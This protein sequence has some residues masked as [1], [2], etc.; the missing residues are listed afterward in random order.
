MGNFP[1][2]HE[3]TLGTAPHLTRRASRV[4]I[5][6]TELDGPGT[7]SEVLRVMGGPMM[8]SHRPERRITGLKIAKTITY[9]L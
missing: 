3:C 2:A 7:L 9:Y 1:Q 4:H 8:T 5:F 6:R